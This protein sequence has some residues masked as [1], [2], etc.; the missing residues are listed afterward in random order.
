MTF[1]SL[2]NQAVADELSKYKREYGRIKLKLQE[3]NR[4]LDVSLN[5]TPLLSFQATFLQFP[6]TGVF[7]SLQKSTRQRDSS[8]LDILKQRE[9]QNRFDVLGFRSW[10]GF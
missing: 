10:T 6:R 2:Q 1:Y 8:Q 9:F 3:A 4:K 7:V 5:P